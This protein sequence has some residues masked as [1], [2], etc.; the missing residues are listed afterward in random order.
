LPG[1]GSTVVEHD[2]VDL[3]A[4]NAALGIGVV[5]RDH[6]ALLHQGR[7]F[8]IGSGQRN[9]D[10]D[11]DALVGGKDRARPQSEAPSDGGSGQLS[12]KRAAGYHAPSLHREA[13]AKPTD[14]CRFSE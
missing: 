5:D 6:R 4:G 7:L 11:G 1:G 9:G 2:Y 14:V 8:R 13:N 12:D 3:V 10:A